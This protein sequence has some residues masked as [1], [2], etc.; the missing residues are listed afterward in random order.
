MGLIHAK[1]NLL[2]M[3]ENGEFDVIVHGAN[4]MCVM[5][6]GIAREI[7]TR[8]PQAENADN[9]TA[10]FDYQKL[11]N[12][13]HASCDGLGGHVFTI[14][15]AYTQFKTSTGGEDVF[16]YVAFLLILQKLAHSISEGGNPV[17]VGFPYIGMGLAH[18]DPDR[19]IGLIEHFESEI[20]KTGSTVTLVEFAK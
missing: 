16:E 5:G 2:D 13:T 8:F 4:C 14:V 11:G 9:A 10:P 15:N 1:G 7:K 3:A 18:G 17:K 19:I 12:Y 20:E 6:S